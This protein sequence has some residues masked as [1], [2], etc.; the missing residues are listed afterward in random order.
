MKCFKHEIY[1]AE[2]HN[3]FLTSTNDKDQ[4]SVYIDLLKELKCFKHE[5]G[6]YSGTA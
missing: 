1:I 6:I 2:L 3:G 4:I 5:I